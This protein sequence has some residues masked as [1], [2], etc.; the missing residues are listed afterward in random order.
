MSLRECRWRK[1]YE[2][3][4]GQYGFVFGCVWGDDSSMKVQ[5]LDLSRITEGILVRDDRFGYV[6]MPSWIGGEDA[7]RPLRELVNV[8]EYAPNVYFA[9][10][11]YFRLDGSEGQFGDR[12]KAEHDSYLAEQEAEREAYMEAHK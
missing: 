10:Q 9:S 5:Y 1:Y 11:R 2:Q 8:S 6:E 3:P 12:T 4:S 7:Q